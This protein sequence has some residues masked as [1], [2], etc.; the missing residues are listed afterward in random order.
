[1]IGL[2][3]HFEICKIVIPKAF[4]PLALTLPYLRKFGISFY[5]YGV[6]RLVGAI[7]L[8][9][10]CQ[11]Y[12]NNVVSCGEELNN[13]CHKKLLLILNYLQRNI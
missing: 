7:I 4:Y 1:M 12:Q 11:G 6:F 10:I 2:A 5:P 3:G 8:M 13:H 9:N